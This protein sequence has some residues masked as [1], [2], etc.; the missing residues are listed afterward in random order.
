M[1]SQNSQAGTP[2]PGSNQKGQKTWPRRQYKSPKRAAIWAT[3]ALIIGEV[4]FILLPIPAVGLVAFIVATVMFL[5]WQV[6]CSMNL[7]PLGNEDQNYSPSSGMMWWF[8][9]LA[10]LVVPCRVVSEIWRGSHPNAK[11]GWKPGQPGVPKS[12]ILI[13][14]WLPFLVSR[15]L[16]YGIYK[17]TTS[18][19]SRLLPIYGITT[20]V[21]LVLVIILIWQIT[22]N[23]EKK[24]RDQAG[25]AQIQSGYEDETLELTERPRRVIR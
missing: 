7:Q 8:F 23:Q 10:N 3:L 18:D 2:T 1:T 6:R 9:P 11:P 14:W 24:R 20:L 16:A 4:A 13:A 22:S 5:R 12:R 19:T 17:G 25:R 21:A 15:F